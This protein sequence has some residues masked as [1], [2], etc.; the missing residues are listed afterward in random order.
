MIHPD[1]DSIDELPGIIGRYATIEQITR[2]MEMDPVVVYHYPEG[3]IHDLLTADALGTYPL[4][5]EV[6]DQLWRMAYRYE[7]D[8][9]EMVT[10]EVLRRARPGRRRRPPAPPRR[11]YYPLRGGGHGTGR[12]QGGKTEY[13]ERWSDEEAV[14][15]V[16]AVAREPDSAVRQPDGTLRACGVRDGVQIRVVVDD[17]GEV[18][19]AYPLP[20]PDVPV[21]PLDPERA[22]WVQRLAALMETGLPPQTPAEVRDGIAEQMSAGE[23]D[24]AL[25]Q[26]MALPGV[27]LDRAELDALLTAAGLPPLPIAPGQEA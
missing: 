9:R 10:P 6:V 11:L 21:N 12:G 18:I 22:P 17:D 15:H 19:T 14:E 1:D 5:D 26:L 27:D 20:G 8:P 16:M 25:S 7:M 13:P 3:A 24:R 4:P 23:W 2:S